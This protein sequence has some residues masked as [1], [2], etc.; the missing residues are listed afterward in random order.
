[1]EA[2]LKVISKA[3]GLEKRRTASLADQTWDQS[4]DDYLLAKYRAFV[5]ECF[6]AG[7]F[8]P[9]NADKFFDGKYKSQTEQI[10]QVYLR[11]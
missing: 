6:S 8:I 3:V 10:R 11:H 9:Y 2:K 7:R 1:M 5:R 4:S